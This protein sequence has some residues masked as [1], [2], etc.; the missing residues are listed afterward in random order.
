MTWGSHG[1]TMPN[2]I[3][4]KLVLTSQDADILEVSDLLVGAPRKARQRSIYFD[5]P[6]HCLVRAGLSLR[7]R[8]SDRKRS[9]TVKA[10]GANSV[11]LFARPE[12]EREVFD[13]TPIIDHTTP[14]PALL[15]ERV[16][17]LAPVFEV[18]VE[19]STWDIREGDATIELVIDRGEAVVAGD[20]RAPICEVELELKH[21]NAAALFVVARKIAA[22]VPIRL[23]VMTKAERGYALIEAVAMVF[24]A[25][26]VALNP[27]MTAA[28]AFQHIVQAC[29]RHYRRN[30][31]LLLAGSRPEA[32]HQ[33]RVALRR[34][35]SAFAIFEMLLIDDVSAGLNDA[36]LW[37]ATELGEARNLDVMLERAPRGELQDQLKTARQLAYA[38]VD[39]VVASTRVRRLMLD[40]AE[41]TASGTWVAAANTRDIRDQPSREFASAAL[42]RFRHKVKKNGRDLAAA[43]DGARHK[44]RK[45]AKK[46]RYAAEFFATLFDRKRERRRH[47]RFI[48]ALEA[49]QEQLGGLTD[50]ATASDVLTRMGIGDEPR[51]AASLFPGNKKNLLDAAEGAHDALVEA[52]RFWR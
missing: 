24:K 32:L 42:D 5:T 4:L 44:V 39:E 15:G 21:G 10:Y 27:E 51:A 33:A 48:G 30:E 35:R 40:L 2:E 29:L 43:D 22:V 11:G 9:Q 28:H 3:E 41:W 34:L 12:W 7:I 14:I 36:L 31:D 26:R 38:R 23:G 25:E 49:L 8:R 45:D 20:R 19:R 52:K 13:D 17:E 46:L 47:K 18:H 6:D 50:L 37:L 1:M 16:T